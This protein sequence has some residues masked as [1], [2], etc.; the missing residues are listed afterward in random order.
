MA[1]KQK[2]KFCHICGMR[3]PQNRSRL[4]M[5]RLNT[6]IRNKEYWY[7]CNSCEIIAIKNLHKEVA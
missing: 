6:N 3:V 1:N 2:N 7:I 5:T 4:N